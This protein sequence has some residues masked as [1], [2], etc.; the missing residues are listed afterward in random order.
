MPTRD[1]LKAAFVLQGILLVSIAP[2][3]QNLNAQTLAWETNDSEGGR[4][5]RRLLTSILDGKGTDMPSFRGK[6]ARRTSRNL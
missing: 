6:F 4:S 5:D 2:G 1:R 3:S